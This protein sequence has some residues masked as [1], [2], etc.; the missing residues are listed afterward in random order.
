M[1]FFTQLRDKD[2][3]A[4]QAV[5]KLLYGISEVMWPPETSALVLYNKLTLISQFTIHPTNFLLLPGKR[6][7]SA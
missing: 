3:E 7:I 2:K 5:R 4:V 6:Q 1:L